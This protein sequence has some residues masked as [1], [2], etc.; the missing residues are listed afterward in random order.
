[1]TIAD[2]VYAKVKVMPEPLAREVLD[3]V[4]VP[5]AREDEGR[6]RHLVKA[7]ATALGGVWGDDEDRVWDE[8]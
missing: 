1:M 4:G 3:F 6:W 7:Q 5:G 2:L 8:L